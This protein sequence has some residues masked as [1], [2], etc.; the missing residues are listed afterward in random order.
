MLNASGL[1]QSPTI[2]DTHEDSDHDE[3]GVTSEVQS[4]EQSK[5]KLSQTMMILGKK[6]ISKWDAKYKKRN[7]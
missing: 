5:H 4:P 3:I 6:T 2:L 7:Q 1:S